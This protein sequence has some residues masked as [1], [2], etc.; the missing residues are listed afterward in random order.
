M[1]YPLTYIYFLHKGDNIPF[2][3][4]KTVNKSIH[5]SHQHKK[6]Y[7]KDTILEI[8]DIINTLDWKFWECYWIEQFR[9]W[10]FHLKNINKGGG[11]SIYLPTKAKIVKSEKMK[12]N[13]EN[14]YF[15]RK[16]DKPVIDNNTG[17]VYSSIKALLKDIGMKNS[18]KA[19]YGKLGEKKRFSYIY[20]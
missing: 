16:W 14:G 17:K 4:G 19:F 12:N 15:K 2:Y 18:Y 20:K 7:G 9:Q 3:V 5:R 11:G 6:T 1:K 13:W 8:L 10:G